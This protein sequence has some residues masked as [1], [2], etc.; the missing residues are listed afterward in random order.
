MQYVQCVAGSYTITNCFGGLQEN[1]DETF[2]RFVDGP[3]QSDQA[4][5]VLALRKRISDL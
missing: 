2:T 3:S 4:S 1:P 5:A